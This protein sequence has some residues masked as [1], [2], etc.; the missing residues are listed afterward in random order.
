VKNLVVDIGNTYTK[1]GVFEGDTCIKRQ[2]WEIWEVEQL[3][4]FAQAQA[5]QNAIICSVNR[6]NPDLLAALSK[7][8]RCMELDHTTTL[9]F[10]NAYDTPQTLGKDRLAAVAGAHALYA[11]QNC[12]VIDCGTCIK[13]DYMRAEEVYEGGNIAPGLMMRIQAMHHFTARL[14]EVPLALPSH[15][16]GK[17]TETALQNGALQGAVLEILGF[18]ALFAQQS[19]DLQVIL[20]G[21]DAEFL[22][23]HLQQLS[24]RHEPNIVLHGLNHI[25]NY[26]L[27]LGLI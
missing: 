1:L 5:V 10:R 19:I 16:I 20:T 18:T 21:G 17:S 15:F 6:Q 25:L 9:P 12:L 24:V 26:N 27:K 7:N 2:V 14:P 4:D 23:P 11:G 8:L 22:I 13:Y 3:G